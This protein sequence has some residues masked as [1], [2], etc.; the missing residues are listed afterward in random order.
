MDSPRRI[1][2]L[3]ASV[4][5]SAA[6]IPY[7]Q[8]VPGPLVPPEG[9][10]VA[11]AELPAGDAS[12][13]VQRYS[14]PV[15][16]RRPGA[17]DDY[18]LRFYAKRERVTPG[19]MVRTGAGGRAEILYSPDASSVVLFEEARVTLGDPERDEPLLRFHSVTRALLTLTSE[20]R[21]ELV[22]GAELRGD[23]ERVSGPILLDAA[24]GRILRITN[25]SK[26][27]VTVEMRDRR[28]GLAPGE[29]LDL[30][31]LATGTAPTPPEAEPERL[32]LEPGV[33]ALFQGEVEREAGTLP[34]WLAAR[35]ASAVRSLGLT[36]TLAP[37]ERVR[38]SGLSAQPASAPADSSV[39]P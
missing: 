21:I 19:T 36:V 23:P 10:P 26:T 12:I 6:C 24:R 38:F 16:I 3:L 30:P 18:P 29:T 20:D 11:A 14:D 22:G 33:L 9:S 4:A 28:L 37:G 13:T 15:F 1:A 5:A 31:L 39:Q 27:D 32:E 25:Q 17:R 2:L 7:P 35:R 34:P 8:R